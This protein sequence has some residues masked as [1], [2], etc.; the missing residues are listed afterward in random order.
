MR[1]FPL[2]VMHEYSVNMIII[3]SFGLLCVP[4]FDEELFGD[5]I[6]E[7]RKKAQD[8]RHFPAA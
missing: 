6:M 2:R 7:S 4:G 5:D 3:S 8:N 1:I